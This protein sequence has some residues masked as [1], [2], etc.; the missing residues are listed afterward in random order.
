MASIPEEIRSDMI[1]L[2]EQCQTDLAEKIIPYWAALRDDEFGG[3][4]GFV[5]F[6][7]VVDRTSEKGGILNS[8]ILYFFSETYLLMKEDVSVWEQNSDVTPEEVLSLAT[9]AFEMLRDKFI[10]TKNDGIYWSV[11]YQGNPLDTTKHTYCQAFAIYG[12]CSYYRATHD[13]EA[14]EIAWNLFHLIESKMRD[15]GGYLE[16]FDREFAPASNEKLSENGVSATRTMNTILHVLEAYTQLLR[17]AKEQACPHREEI[18]DEAGEALAECLRFV[19]DKIYNPALSRQEVFFDKDYN[20]LIDLYSYGHDTE[21]AWLL[22]LAGEILA[23]TTINQRIHE[24]SKVMEENILKVGFDGHSLP[25]ECE[26]GVVLEDRN[27]WVEAETVNGFLHAYVKRPEE[28]KYYTATRSTFDYICEKVV[29][30][31]S[32]EWFARLDKD[33]NPVELPMTEPWKCPYHNGRMYI[34]TIR[35]VRD[36]HL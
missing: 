33:G 6:N 15:E 19:L 4:Y 1:K 16:A 11:D 5:D 18:L 13:N 32:G 20:S 12:L 10:D 29:D 3:F 26:A 17:I 23:D 35:A 22:D 14:L 21:A 24:M 9:H 8:R 30:A 36:L 34:E 2:S 7:L 25:A 31:R 28:T 27:W